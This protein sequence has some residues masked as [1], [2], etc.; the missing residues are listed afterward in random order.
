MTWQS[1]DKIPQDLL[2]SQSDH[3]KHPSLAQ[4]LL[5]EDDVVVAQ[6]ISDE[7][8]LGSGGASILLIFMKCVRSAKSLDWLKKHKEVAE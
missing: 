2:R 3:F 6:E 5:L 8:L 4:T 1:G 7:R